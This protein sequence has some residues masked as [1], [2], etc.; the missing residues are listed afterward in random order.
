MQ[1]KEWKIH[2]LG[3]MAKPLTEPKKIQTS[4]SKNQTVI[5]DKDQIGAVIG[6]GGKVIQE[7]QKETGATSQSS[8]RRMITV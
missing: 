2:I 6:P 5:I 4:C 3:E 8:K 7:I 1:A